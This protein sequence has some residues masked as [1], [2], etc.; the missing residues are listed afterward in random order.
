ME[1]SKRGNRRHQCSRPCCS[2]CPDQHCHRWVVPTFSETTGQPSCPAATVW[3][4]AAFSR[5]GRSCAAGLDSLMHHLALT[6][7]RPHLLLHCM[8]RHTHPH[9]HCGMPC[10]QDL[11]NRRL[12]SVLCCW[13]DCGTSSWVSCK[14]YWL[15]RSW[16]SSPLDLWGRWALNTIKGPWVGSVSQYCSTS[17]GHVMQAKW[18][19]WGNARGSVQKSFDLTGVLWKSGNLAPCFVFFLCV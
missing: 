11:P 7:Y 19:D 17:S 4:P 1:P 9:M 16:K 8:H 3:Q 12:G 10:H 15:P 18:S 13:C 5:I 14:P 6:H 2:W